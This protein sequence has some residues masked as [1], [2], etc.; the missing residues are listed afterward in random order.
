MTNV[1]SLLGVSVLAFIGG[2]MFDDYK[3]LSRR[4]KKEGLATLIFVFLI[5]VAT[6]L[7]N[8]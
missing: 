7:L 4:E 3:R 1:V 2:L 5:L 8:R 6:G